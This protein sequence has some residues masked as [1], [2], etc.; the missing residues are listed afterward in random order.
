MGNCGFEVGRG[1]G[2][3]GGGI[4]GGILQTKSCLGHPDGVRE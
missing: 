2:K 3:F 1:G 4:V